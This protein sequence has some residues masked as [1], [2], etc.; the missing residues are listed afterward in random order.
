MGGLSGFAAD[1]LIRAPA[2]F[3]GSPEERVAFVF[4]TAYDYL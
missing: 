4:M 2:W 3:S 1:K